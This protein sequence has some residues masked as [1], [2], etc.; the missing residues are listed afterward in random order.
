M[1]SNLGDQVDLLG[2][3][4]EPTSPTVKETMQLTLY[5]QAR[6]EMDAD[7]TVF[8]HL[9]DGRG[10]IVAQHDGQPDSGTYPTS[11]WLPGEVVVD[12]HALVPAP[13][14]GPGEYTLVVGLYDREDG[15]RLLAYDQDGLALPQNRIALTT[16]RVQE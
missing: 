9:V 2:Y 16:I 14:Y 12:E 4:V 11:Q 1:Y 5:W 8:I 13:G 3:G 7:Y 10:N 6:A 15:E